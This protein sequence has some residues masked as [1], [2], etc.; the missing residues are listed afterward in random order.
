MMLLPGPNGPQWVASP[1]VPELHG[2]SAGR[3]VVVGVSGSEAS[4]RAIKTAVRATGGTSDVILVCATRRSRRDE[5]PTGLHD[6]LKD[7]S[8]LLSGQAT[9]AEQLRTARELAI[10]LGARSVVTATDL[11]DPVAV[12][13]RAV[14]RFG[15]GAVVLGTSGRRPGWTARSLAR[16]LDAEVDLVVTDGTRHHRRRFTT[17][18]AS[19]RTLRWTPGWTVP[20]RGLASR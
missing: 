18:E 10:W 6:A 16:H 13:Q 9:V 1:A 20:Q 12:M 4:R 5:A 17:R 7:E 15:A 2:L 3:P 11:G 19:L 14:E 8:Y